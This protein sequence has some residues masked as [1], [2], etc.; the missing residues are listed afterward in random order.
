MVH[1][2]YSEDDPTD[3]VTDDSSDPDDQ[4]VELR[5]ILPMVTSVPTNLVGA[6]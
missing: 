2:V 1:M 4:R 6:K 3:K 5:P